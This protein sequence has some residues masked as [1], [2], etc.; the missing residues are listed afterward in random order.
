MEGTQK[1][2]HIAM[3]Q[4]VHVC[5]IGTGVGD[6]TCTSNDIQNVS[7]TADSIIVGFNVKVERQAAELAE[8]LDFVQWWLQCH[9][10]C[11]STP[12]T[13]CPTTRLLRRL[14]ELIPVHHAP[15]PTVEVTMTGPQWLS[16][17]N[18]N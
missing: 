17:R 11:H 16:H 5:V 13:G 2:V 4:S 6:T 1:D 14:S 8:R 12:C 3:H 7:A 10:L 18:I 15:K 9:S